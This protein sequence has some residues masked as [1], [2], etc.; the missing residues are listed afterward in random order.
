MAGQAA[1]HHLVPALLH[2]HLPHSTA[3]STIPERTLTI[4]TSNYV[5]HSILTPLRDI[6]LGYRLDNSCAR[7]GRDLASTS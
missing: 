2:L 7:G 6:L 4:Q 5:L 1:R 3:K